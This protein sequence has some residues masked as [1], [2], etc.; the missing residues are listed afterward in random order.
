MKLRRIYLVLL[1]VPAFATGGMAQSVQAVSS[2]QADSMRI[3]EQLTY[4]LDFKMPLDFTVE[5]PVWQ[6]TLVAGIEILNVGEVQEKLL[7]GEEQKWLR[8]ELLIT[9]FD[10]GTYPIP[11]TELSFSPKN[12]SVVFHAQTNPLLLSV[13][14][15]QV[16]T[17]QTFKPIKGPV[18]AP[19]GFWE[20]FPWVIGVLGFLLLVLLIIWFFMRRSPKEVPEP[21][22]QKPK[23]PPHIIALNQLEALRQQKLWQ[24]G[25]LKAYHSALSEIVRA[26]IDGRF[27]IHAIEMTTDE[28]LASVDMLNI[29]AD[30]RAKLARAL[31]LGDMVK[32]AKAE[33]SG[34]ENDLCLTHIIDFVNE[35]HGLSA[36]ETD[37][38]NHEN[39]GTDYESDE[40]KP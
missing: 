30:A 38:D 34:L 39:S 12:D 36:G 26:Y 33:P 35:S 4:A 20:V 15:V 19:L 22:V 28:I 6:D 23:I 3:G 7:G 24:A 2:L 31:Q 10:A 9:A 13:Y 21:V 8:Q 5:W 37:D 32:F 27:G 18:A 17:T 14:T 29:N 16:D 11:G 40:N 25:K 1:L